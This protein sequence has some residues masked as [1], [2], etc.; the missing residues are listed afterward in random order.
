MENKKAKKI[1][2]IS[3]LGLIALRIFSLFLI[4][5]LPHLEQFRY[6]SYFSAIR[7]GDEEKYFN[8][9]K[10]I[11]HLSFK[12]DAAM[13]GFS[14]MIVPFIFF[15]GENYSN[16]F[17]PLVIFNGIFLF[18]LTLILLAWASFLIFKKIWP[19]VLS[20]SLFLLFPFIFYLFRGYGPHFPTM[21]WNDINFLNMNWLAAMADEPAAFFASL[22]LFLLLVAGRKN[23]GPVFYSL[24]GFIAG[25]SAMVR[26]TN[27]VIV[28]AT[29]LI[30]FLY[31]ASRK[32]KNLFFYCSSVLI[33]FL[34]QFMYNT[35]FFGSPIS[36]GYQKDYNTSWVAAGYVNGPMWGFDNFF[37]LF[38]RA[39]DYSL[40]AIPAFLLLFTIILLGILYI[41][42]INKRHAFIIGLWFFSLTLIY[43]FFQ[44]G[45]CAPRYYLPAVPAFIILMTAVL[46]RISNK[47]KTRFISAK[48]N[49]F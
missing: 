2:I 20:G 12:P 28:A 41:A 7:E 5:Y 30:I 44:T 29:A 8:M 18:S 49:I 17:F 1:L 9:A 31:E 21:A 32:Y 27:I 4:P 6:T 43:M 11:Y 36:F 14:L 40:L 25:F 39:A 16:V 34:P 23:F 10:M 19:A 46:M 24:L 3:V 22:I 38:S 45:Q 15:G 48:E 26:I 42:K 13:L 35:V 37:H 33:A 47:I